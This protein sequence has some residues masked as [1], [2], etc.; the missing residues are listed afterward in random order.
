MNEKYNIKTSFMS[1]LLIPLM[2][3]LLVIAFHEGNEGIPR[4]EN[5]GTLIIG[6]ALVPRSAIPLH[7]LHSL[8]T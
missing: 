3:N 5:C 4:N 8:V 7:G 2:R 6:S 1:L